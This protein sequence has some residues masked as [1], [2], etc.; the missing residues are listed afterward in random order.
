MQFDRKHMNDRIQ[1]VGQAEKQ[2]IRSLWQA[3]FQ[4]PEPFADYYFQYV[5]GKNRVLAA[6][7]GG[8]ICSM[9]HLN[10]Y[11]WCQTDSI[12]GRERSRFLLHY[13]VGVATAREF[14][15]KG[16][17][18]RCLTKA[19]QDME[20]DGEPFT[21][22]MPA[23]KEY[24]E[25]FQFVTLKEESAWLHTADGWKRTSGTEDI[26]KPLVM[27]NDLPYRLFP[28]RD[29]EYM[30]RLRTETAAEG[31]GL[32]S[33]STHG[34]AA[35]VQDRSGP[36]GK[37]VIR[38][39]F[40]GADGPCKNVEE[41]LESVILPE[42]FQMYGPTTVEYQEA[43]TMMIRI[44][45]LDRFVELLPYGQET[46]QIVVNVKDTICQGNHGTFRITLAKEGCSL[47]PLRS[48]ESQAQYDWDIAEL[49]AYLLKETSFAEQVYLMEE[50]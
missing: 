34:Y 23:R 19:L 41:L 42:L 20:A 12:T 39:M 46:K 43:Q 38:Q 37:V 8:R 6:K 28:V 21:Y 9:L 4:D 40:C 17:M 47:V 35:Y 14:R 7:S 32:I 31:G 18:A 22:L 16:Y 13:I 15:R 33:W 45:R 5:Y 29:A 10:P 50:V 44:I 36:H 30:E 3:A 49:T 2:E 25:P 26:R 1:Y 11:L 48:E 24:Y 27:Q